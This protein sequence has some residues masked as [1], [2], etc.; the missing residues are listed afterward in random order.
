MVDA[1]YPRGICSPIFVIEYFSVL[2]L[3]PSVLLI[4]AS[5][6][7]KIIHDILPDLRY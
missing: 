1:E 5:R 4:Q 6:S 2:F 7:E 3:D